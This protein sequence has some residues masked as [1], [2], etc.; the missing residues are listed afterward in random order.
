MLVDTYFQQFKTQMP[1]SAESISDAAMKTLCAY[2]RRR[3][4]LPST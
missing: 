4:I 2:D 3:D 1:T